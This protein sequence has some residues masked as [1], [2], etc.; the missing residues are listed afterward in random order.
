MLRQD[1]KIN[2]VVTFST[3][4]GLEKSLCFSMFPDTE[5]KRDHILRDQIVYL[6]FPSNMDKQ[7]RSIIASVALY[8]K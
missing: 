6:I 2:T 4:T 3:V 8:S 1:C 7:S 5:A